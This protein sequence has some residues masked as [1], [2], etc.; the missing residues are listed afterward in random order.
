MRLLHFTSVSASQ[1]WIRFLQRCRHIPSAE[2]IFHKN[3]TI[4]IV[5]I[6]RHRALT[7]SLHDEEKLKLG[8]GQKNIYL[9]VETGLIVQIVH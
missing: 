6:L 4:F 3:N 9:E 2:C 7:G 1:V 5:N 8:G